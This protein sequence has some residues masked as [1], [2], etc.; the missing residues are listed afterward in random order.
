MTF[1]RVSPVSPRLALR[2][3]WAGMIRTGLGLSACMALLSGCQHREAT[4]VTAD[5]VHSLEGGEIYRLHPPTPGYDQPYPHIGRTPTTTPDFPSPE[6]RTAL[7]QQLEAQRNTAQRLSA[8]SGPLPRSNRLNPLPPAPG[9]GNSM[10]MVSQKQGPT[11]APPAPV[12]HTASSQP[13]GAS[14]QLTYQP[15]DHRVPHSLPTVSDAPPPPI[16]FPGFHIPAASEQLTPDFD[17][18]T[19]AGTLLRF[20]PDSDHL[21]DGQEDTLTTLSQGQ[22]DNYVLIRG[23]GSALSASSGLSPEDQQNGIHLGLLRAKAVAQQL[24]SRGVPADMIELRADPIGNGVRVLY[25][26]R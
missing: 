15:I 16:T 5:W 1:Q 8:A 9:N 7:T 2:P 19:P 3:S 10:T 18:A 26:L 20:Q 11:A 21:K 25:R 23:F 6:A 14:S 24:I 4:T 22:H 13:Q 12:S 17:S